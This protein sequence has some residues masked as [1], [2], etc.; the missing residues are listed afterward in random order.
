MPRSVIFDC[1]GDDNDLLAHFPIYNVLQ[2]GS[3]VPR[4]DRL[5]EPS[6]RSMISFA[7]KAD[8]AALDSNSLVGWNGGG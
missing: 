4:T 2:M 1:R 5:R 7:M 8:H 6:P 3:I